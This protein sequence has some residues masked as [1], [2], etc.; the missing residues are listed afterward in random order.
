MNGPLLI[1]D[2]SKLCD[3]STDPR[4]QITTQD[5]FKERNKISFREGLN[6]ALYNV[7]I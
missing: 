6:A 2:V 4:H 7:N 3:V 5:R 1:T